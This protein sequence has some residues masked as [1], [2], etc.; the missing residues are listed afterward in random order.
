MYLTLS[1]HGLL[2]TTLK[3]QQ[4]QEM[5]LAPLSPLH[6]RVCLTVFASRP[7]SVSR[8]IDKE[9]VPRRARQ[10]HLMLSYEAQGR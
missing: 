1:S 3:I 5:V 8:W 6:G 10:S 7:P 2:Y 9:Y 4:G